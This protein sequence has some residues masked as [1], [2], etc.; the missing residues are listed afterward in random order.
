MPSQKKKLSNVKRNQEEKKSNCGKSFFPPPQEAFVCADV[1]DFYEHQVG[2][3]LAGM[4]QKMVYPSA[5]EG[6]SMRKKKEAAFHKQQSCARQ[7]DQRK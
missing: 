2:D 1:S 7:K 6:Q 5:V 3:F 4:T